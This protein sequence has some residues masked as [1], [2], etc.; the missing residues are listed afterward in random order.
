MN[1]ID[2]AEE[3]SYLTSP[4]NILLGVSPPS[5]W[6]F[7]SSDNSPLGG[8]SF[9]NGGYV[10]KIQKKRKPKKAFDRYL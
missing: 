2:G 8:E 3:V 7:P 1:D 9:S 4:G 10:G 5:P 6:A